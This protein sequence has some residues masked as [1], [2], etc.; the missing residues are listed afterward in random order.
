VPIT[1]RCRTSPDGHMSHISRRS[2]TQDRQH[3]AESGSFKSRPALGLLTDLE[4]FPKLILPCPQSV[5]HATMRRRLVIASQ[6]VA[7][8]ISQPTLPAVNYWTRS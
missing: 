7:S 5:P 6:A 1:T 2:T 4:A 3:T 8:G